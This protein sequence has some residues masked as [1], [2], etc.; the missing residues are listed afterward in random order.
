M[1]KARQMSCRVYYLFPLGERT[2][3]DWTDVQGMNF[4]LSA[5]RFDI[6]LPDQ[7]DIYSSVSYM[8]NK[9]EQE[10]GLWVENMYGR[11]FFVL[12][13]AVIGITAYE[14]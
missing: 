10:G 1:S 13:S 5:R 8:S 4:T 2:P 9:V 3:V 12:K 7:K 14:V 11:P 6:I